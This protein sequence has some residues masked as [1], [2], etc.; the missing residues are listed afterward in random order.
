[1]QVNEQQL[2]QF[3][4]QVFQRYDRDHSGTL[5]LHELAA[6]FNE[7]FQTMGSPARLN[8]Q[9]ASD[10]LRAIDRNMDGKATQD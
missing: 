10:A 6:F 2:R 4:A 7:V 1:M 8:Q 5:E 9:Q 3:V